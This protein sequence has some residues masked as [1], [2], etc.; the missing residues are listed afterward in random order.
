[1]HKNVA[2]AFPKNI[3]P[4]SPVERFFSG[5]FFPCSNTLYEQFEWPIEELDVPVLPMLWSIMH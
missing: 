4:F 5:H 2:D 3:R 1:M